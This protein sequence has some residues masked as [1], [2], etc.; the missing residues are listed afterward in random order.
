MRAARC[1]NIGLW[2][3][4]RL[5]DLFYVGLVFSIIGMVF[6]TYKTFRNKNIL[7]P[8]MIMFA[9]ILLFIYIP[10]ALEKYNG[11]NDFWYNFALF[12]GVIGAY[13][14]SSMFPYNILDVDD[15]EQIVPNIRLFKLCSYVYVLYLLYEIFVSIRAYGSI[16]AVFSSNRLSKY[17]GEGLVGGSAIRLLMIEGLK[18]F[19]YVYIAMLYEQRKKGKA[20]ALFIIPMIHHLFTAVTRYD[21]I[22]MAGA[23]I[24]YIVDNK[25]YSKSN[26][27]DAMEGEVKKPINIFKITI[28]GVLVVYL[29]LMFMTIANYVRHG[30]TNVSSISFSIGSLFS[31]LISNDSKYYE[32]CYEVFQGIKDGRMQYEYGLT[33]WLYVIVNFIPRSIWPSK[34]YTSFSVRATEALYWSYTSGNPVVTFSIFGEGFGQLGYIGCFL[35]PILFLGCRWINFRQVKRIKYNRLYI[36]VIIFSMFTYMRAEVPVFYAVVVGLWLWAISSYCE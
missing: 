6:V 2:E 14:A 30:I 35:C 33:W 28:V 31:N 25:M 36:M 29:A 20:I 18:I 27:S 10:A 13:V 17:L 23:L 12:L 16:G 1:L 4:R 32:Y 3:I 19:F 8:Q 5:V 7:S 34:P 11:I 9:G 24:L 26:L 21:F 15:G 22:A